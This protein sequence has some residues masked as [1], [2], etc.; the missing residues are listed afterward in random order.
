[1]VEV[2]YLHALIGRVPLVEWHRVIGRALADAKKGDAKARDWLSK[3]LLGP[4]RAAAEKQSIT[5]SAESGSN[6]FTFTIATGPQA[7]A[8]I[9]ITPPPAGGE[10]DDGGT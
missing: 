10:E 6:T 8:A 3:Y 4:E 2:E 5:L 7:P 1:M 9:D